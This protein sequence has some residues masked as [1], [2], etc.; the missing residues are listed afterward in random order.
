MNPHRD[1]VV[2]RS[3]TIDDDLALASSSAIEVTVTLVDERRRWLFFMTP[4]ALASC[5][6]W[7]EGTHVRMHLGELHM[8]VVEDITR[9]IIERVLRHL[10]RA[11]QLE[12]RT[13]PLGQA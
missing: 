10:D 9:D 2:L 4:A 1:A 12:R 11:G 7:V 13:L 6:D 8:I 3:Y 5:G